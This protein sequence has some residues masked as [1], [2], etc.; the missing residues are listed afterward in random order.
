MIPK[1]TEYKNILTT[2]RYHMIPKTQCNTL[3]SRF[4]PYAL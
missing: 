2:K 1:S 3:A 4:Y